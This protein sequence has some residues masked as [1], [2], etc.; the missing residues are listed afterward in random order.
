MTAYI[1]TLLERFI[2][3][4]DQRKYRKDTT[5][6]YEQANY[7]FKEKLSDMQRAVARL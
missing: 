2:V 3:Q 6:K 7:Y 4:K 5:N 1:E